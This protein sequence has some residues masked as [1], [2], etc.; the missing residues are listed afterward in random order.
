MATVWQGMIRKIESY[1][2]SHFYVFSSCLG[3]LFYTQG[4]WWRWRS[5][6]GSRSAALV[7]CQ[8]RPGPRGLEFLLCCCRRCDCF[9]GLFGVKKGV[10]L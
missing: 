8:A 9:G 4:V 2:H 10:F 6:G 1:V 5:D 7:R 3:C